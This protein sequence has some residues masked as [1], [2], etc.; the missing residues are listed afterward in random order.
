MFFIKEKGTENVDLKKLQE[1]TAKL[2]ELRNQKENLSVPP[3]YEDYEDSDY[4]DSDY[5]EADDDRDDDE[6]D[7]F[8]E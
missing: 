2:E 7:G 1:L 6:P 3:Q 8:D 4:E 5:E